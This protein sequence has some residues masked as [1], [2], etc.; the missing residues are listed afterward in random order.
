[1]RT[2]RQF[3][4]LLWSLVVPLLVACGSQSEPTPTP[5]PVSAVATAT[6]APAPTPTRAITPTPVP[7]PTT[8]PVTPTPSPR[9][10]TQPPLE[11]WAN[12][13]QGVE[14]FVAEFISMDVNGNVLYTFE[15]WH[16]APDRSR[17]VGKMPSGQDLEMIVIGERAW[18]RLGP[19][20]T[21]QEV[22]A[23]QVSGLTG[24]AAP[25]DVYG[26]R[27]LGSPGS[28]PQFEYAGTELLDG[29]LTH[30]W[31]GTMGSQPSATLT[32]WIGEDDFP[33][34]MRVESPDG[35]LEYRY[36]RIN[37]PLGIEPPIP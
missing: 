2:R 34:R 31:R 37:E 18:I 25:E 10:G 24:G 28:L 7:T 4:V 16:E 32:I 33:R 30:V 22:P 5:A 23:S 13:W 12:A 26:E 19:S 14:S 9:E 17:I 11:R 15:L 36:R 27:I 1:M 29:E 20:G 6:P 3:V 35:T 8:E 21:W